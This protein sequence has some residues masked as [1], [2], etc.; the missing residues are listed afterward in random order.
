MEQFN[1]KE[2]KNLYFIY[3]EYIE[4]VLTQKN[5]DYKKFSDS[6]LNQTHI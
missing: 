1:K 3:L 2:R 6:A 4:F 5:L